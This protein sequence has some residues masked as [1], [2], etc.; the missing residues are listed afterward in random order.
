MESHNQP[1]FAT[2]SSTG[3]R[4]NNAFVEADDLVDC[5]VNPPRPA[6]VKWSLIHLITVCLFAGP[7][8]LPGR[9]NSPSSPFLYGRDSF[10]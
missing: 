2:M 1:T 5:T 6:A 3:I 10:M 4:N 9:M 7:D 8:L